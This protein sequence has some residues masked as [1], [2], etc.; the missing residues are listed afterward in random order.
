[1]KLKDTTLTFVHVSFQCFSSFILCEA[2]LI[3][4]KWRG[5]INRIIQGITF[6]ASDRSL[7]LAQINDLGSDLSIASIASCLQVLVSTRQGVS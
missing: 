7:S 2:V 4:T 5:V 6:E 3:R 1:M